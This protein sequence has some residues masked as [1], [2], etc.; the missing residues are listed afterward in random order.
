MVPGDESHASYLGRCRALGCA[1]KIH[2]G[3][4]FCRWCWSLLHPVFQRDLK[5]Y[6]R[7]LG[8]GQTASYAYLICQRRAIQYIEEVAGG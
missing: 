5:M 2:P 6:V 3:D 7:E 4:L 1:R 8:V